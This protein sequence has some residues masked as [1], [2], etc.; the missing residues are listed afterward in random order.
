LN[1]PPDLI[2]PLS[3]EWFDEIGDPVIHE[4]RNQDG[5]DPWNLVLFSN[6]P[7]HYGDDLSP[8]P[9]GNVVGLFAKDYQDYVDNPESIQAIYEASLKFGNL[10]S[11]FQELG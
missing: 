4:F 6:F 2:T 10:P 5:H 1:L 9:K 3:Q 8:A 7:H 11:S